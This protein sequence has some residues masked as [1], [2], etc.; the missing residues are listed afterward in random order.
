VGGSSSRSR[1]LEQRRR[2]LPWHRGPNAGCRHELYEMAVWSRRALIAM[3]TQR[4]G[5]AACDGQHTLFVLSLIHL[6]LRSMKDCPAQRTMSATSRGGAF[7]RSVSVSFSSDRKCIQRTAGGAEMTPGEM[8]NRWS[9][10]RGPMTRAHLDVR[11]PGAGFERWVANSDAGYEDGCACVQS[12]RVVQR[13]S[14]A[15]Q[16]NLVVTDNSP[17]PSVAG[18]SQSVGFAPQPAPVDA[19]WPRAASAEHESRSLRPLPPRM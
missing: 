16:R 14:Q 10:P 7:M 5:A 4:G 13:R 3:S 8:P 17:C 2:A 6:R 12:Q 9:S 19:Q 11:G 1:G 18:N 15:V